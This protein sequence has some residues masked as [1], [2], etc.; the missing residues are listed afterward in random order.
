MTTAPAPPTPW[1]SALSTVYLDSRRIG[2]MGDPRPAVAKIIA[3]GGRVPADVRVVR[4]TSPDG[5]GTPVHLEDIVDRTA[6]PTAAIYLTCVP[7]GERDATPGAAPPDA[8]PVPLGPAPP[9]RGP[10]PEQPSPVPSQQGP[11]AQGPPGTPSDPV[12]R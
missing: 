5:T 3:V 11:P 9:M 7:R 1:I 8:W 6:D 10:L 2:L 12:T 4:S